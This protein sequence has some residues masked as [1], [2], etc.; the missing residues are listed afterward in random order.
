MKF[1]KMHGQGNDFV[2]I[3]GVRQE[4]SMTPDVARKVVQYFQ[5]VGEAPGM[6]KLTKR[7]RE[8]LDCLAQGWLYKEIADRLGISIETA[9]K[10]LKNIYRKLQVGT[11]TRHEGRIGPAQ[12]SRALESAWSL[13]GA[14]NKYLVDNEPWTL[15]EK[16]DETSRSRFATNCPRN[17][18]GGL[19]LRAGRRKAGQDQ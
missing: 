1:A 14:V 6:E 17:D 15:G 12:F 13:V 8:V 9:R 5:Q 7:E 10:H 19:R 3:D 16:P 4:I 18:S 11:R 2:V